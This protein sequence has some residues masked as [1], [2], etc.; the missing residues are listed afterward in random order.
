M[1]TLLH[2]AH[3]SSSYGLPNGEKLIRPLSTLDTWTATK[4]RTFQVSHRLHIDLTDRSAGRDACSSA[5]FD[6]IS[7]LDRL[8]TPSH[9]RAAPVLLYLLQADILPGLFKSLDTAR[10]RRNTLSHGGQLLV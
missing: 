6:L 4:D 3:A 5:S 9:M 2:I 10:A 8:P 1:D 7:L